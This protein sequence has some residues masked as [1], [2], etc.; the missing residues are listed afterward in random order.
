MYMMDQKPE[1]LKEEMSNSIPE[2]VISDEANPEPERQIEP[3]DKPEAQL[4]FRL[5]QAAAQSKVGPSRTKT[6]RKLKVK[7]TAKRPDERDI[8]NFSRGITRQKKGVTQKRILNQTNTTFSSSQLGMG[9]LLNY[10]IE[11]IYSVFCT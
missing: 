1:T 11:P 3:C 2:N 7:G 10:L 4:I 5:C 9:L 8:D 6:Q